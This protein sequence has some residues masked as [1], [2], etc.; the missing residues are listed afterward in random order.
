MKT[1]DRIGSDW[2]VSSEIHKLEARLWRRI[3]KDRIRALLITSPSRGDGKSTAVAYLAT[4]LALHPER[5]ILAADLDFRDPQLN[6]HF[7]FEVRCGLG[8]ALRGDCRV[9][10]TI[11]KTD[12]P[13]LDLVLPAPGGD[14]PTLLLKTRECSAVIDFFREHYDLAL[15][16]VPALLPVAD[17]SAVLPFV[18]GVVL[19]AMASKTTRPALRRAREICAGMEARILGLIVGNL[20]EGVPE[21]GD[22]RYYD[23]YRRG[24]SRG[25]AAAIA[26]GAAGAAG[27]GSRTAE[28]D[29]APGALRVGRAPRSE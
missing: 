2:Q 29:R 11:I 24:R 4:A 13:N 25:E 14:D 10:D 26:P 16:D 15:L 8:R 12:L 3:R 28:S 21:Y 1:L 23:S 7:G 22:A 6:A 27:A 5:R 17:A 9:E 20:E 19:V 18:D